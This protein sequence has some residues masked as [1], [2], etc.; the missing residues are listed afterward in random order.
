M[1][2]L[3]KEAALASKRPRLTADCR[4]GVKQFEELVHMAVTWKGD[5]DL[6]SLICPPPSSPRTNSWSTQPVG[7]WMLKASGVIYDYAVLAPNTKISQVR[8]RGSQD[9]TQSSQVNTP[10][11]V[12][13][14]S[15]VLPC[16]SFEGFL[17]TTSV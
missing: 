15:K 13:N 7:E 3:L 1:L 12:R 5:K 17:Y 6:H 11:G 4:V 8:Q 9:L 16:W 10:Q 2:I 14:L